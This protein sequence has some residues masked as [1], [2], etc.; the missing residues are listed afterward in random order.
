MK[1]RFY[2]LSVV[3]FDADDTLWHN[4]KYFQLSENNFA[5]LLSEYSTRSN[6][7]SAFLEVERRNLNYYGFGIKG[8]TLSMIE[9]AI[10]ITDG[11]VPVTVI[12]QILELG[13]EMLSQPL[14]LLPSI[15]ETVETLSS[16]LKIIL[17]TKGDLLDQERKLAQS[18]LGDLFHGIEIVSNKSTEIYRRIFNQHGTGPKFGVMVGNSIRSDIV[19]ALQAGAWAIHVPHIVEWEYEKQDPPINHPRFRQVS[20]FSEIIP[21]IRKICEEVSPN[22]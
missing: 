8:F 4:E 5:D 19:P 16:E 22:E 15:R 7:R 14:E 21:M 17:I 6:V 9:T 13:R 10:N 11:R 2:E 20:E 18:G 12:Q 3:G 1:N